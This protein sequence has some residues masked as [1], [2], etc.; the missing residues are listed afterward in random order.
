MFVTDLA[1]KPFKSKKLKILV[2]DLTVGQF[3]DFVSA[4]FEIANK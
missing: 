2:R 1:G 3:L 4:Q